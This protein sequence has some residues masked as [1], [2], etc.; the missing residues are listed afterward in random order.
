MKI[1]ILGLG[2]IARKA[3]LPL[4]GQWPGITPVLCTRNRAMG[5]QLSRRYRVGQ[6]V[7][8]Y[9]ALI[10]TGIDAVMIH[11]A[12]EA[13]EALAAYFLQQGLPVF[14][15]KPLADSAA[16]CERLYELAERHRQPLY[17]GFNRRHLPLLAQQLPD[18]QAGQLDG[19]RAIR[20]EK[21]R[22]NLPGELRTFVFDDFIHAL[23]SVNLMGRAS[24]DGV[25]LH[26][27][28]Q[29]DRLARLE[30]HWQDQQVLFHA[31]MNRLAGQTCETIS[32]D[33]TNDS[34]V[35][36]GFNRGRH[37]H[38]GQ[39][40]HFAL[41][42]WTPMLDSKG[43]RAMLVDWLQVV[44]RGQLPAGVAQRNLASH[45]LAEQLC[46]QLQADAAA[47]VSSNPSAAPWAT[48]PAAPGG[49]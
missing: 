3:Y 2:D 31:S 4:I 39:E 13:H 25:S 11:A 12:T 45:Q 27:Q 28:W 16:A 49:C 42:D 15:D 37:W 5:E 46:A 17:V 38:G 7:E 8:D 10:G 22:H 6:G 36:D 48:N 18:L 44:E 40:R 9:R 35:F 26:S 21:H 47:G 14:V 29:Q 23:D 24:L 43:F 41:P 30:L 20:W 19:L 34:L 1:G 33:R 32:I